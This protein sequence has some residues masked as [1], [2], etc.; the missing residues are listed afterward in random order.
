[1]GV[2]FEQVGAAMATMTA[3]STPAASA[4]TQLN[5]MFAELG[6]SGTTASKA[7]A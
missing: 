7:L 1:M 6:K 3:Q 5:S 4:T 2:S